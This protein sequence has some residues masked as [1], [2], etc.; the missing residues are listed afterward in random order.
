M[1]CEHSYPKELIAQPHPRRMAKPGRSDRGAGAGGAQSVR[2]MLDG[3][4]RNGNMNT[5]ISTP[6]RCAS[7]VDC[8]FLCRQ[9]LGTHIA[10]WLTMSSLNGLMVAGRHGD[11]EPGTGSDSANIPPLQI[12]GDEYVLNGERFRHP[13]ER[14]DMVV[15]LR[16]MQGVLP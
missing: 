9:G 11:T 14:A 3:E 8:C 7:D 15:L 12:D 1:I 13:R 16:H 4:T 10:L 2:R 6:S 5:V